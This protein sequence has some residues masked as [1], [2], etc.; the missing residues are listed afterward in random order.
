MRIN[1]VHQLEAKDLCLR[2][3]ANILFDIPKITDKV[4]RNQAKK[5]GEDLLGVR[6]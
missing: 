4:D 5:V 1:I 2:N 3:A 6:V